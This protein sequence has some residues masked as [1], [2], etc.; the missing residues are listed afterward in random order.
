MIKRLATWLGLLVALLSLI[1]MAFGVYTHDRE[2][3]DMQSDVRQ[4]QNDVHD[5][6]MACKVLEVKASISSKDYTH[7]Y[8][9]PKR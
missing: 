9:K 7:T 8:C 6:E 3:A 4:L 1:T 5:K 2:I